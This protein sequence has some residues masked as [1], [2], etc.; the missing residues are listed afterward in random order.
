MLV[1]TNDSFFF[2]T[3]SDGRRSSFNITRCREKLKQHY[4]TSVCKIPVYPGSNEFLNMEDIYTDLSILCDLP[5]PVKPITKLLKDYTEMFTKTNK[6]MSPKRLLVLG[7]GG[8]GKSTLVG[9]IAYDWANIINGGI[10]QESGIAEI[11]PLKSISIL[12]VLNLRNVNEETTLEE[13]IR[14]QRLLPEDVGFTVEDMYEYINHNEDNTLFIFDSYDEMEVESGYLKSSQSNISKILSSKLLTGCRVLVTSR[15][16]KAHEFTQD[17]D[18][19][20]LYTKF[21]LEGF[22]KEQVE[23]YVRTFFHGNNKELGETLL[24]YFEDNNLCP[25]VAS[26]PLMTQLMCIYWRDKGGK[27]IPSKMTAFY[28]EI[29]QLM[30]KQQHKTVIARDFVNHLGQVA[31]SGLWYPHNKLV[32]PMEMVSTYVPKIEIEGAFKIGLLKRET[33]LNTDEEITNDT[34]DYASFF[35]RTFQECCA[36]HC[37]ASLGQ[38]DKHLLETKLNDLQ[39][40]KVCLQLKTILVHACGASS[41]VGKMIIRRLLATFGSTYTKHIHAYYAD[42]LEGTRAQEVQ[43]F[44]EICLLCNYESGSTVS[45]ME[46]LSTLFPKGN[47][48]F[49]GMNPYTSAAVGY[50][51]EHLNNEITQSETRSIVIMELPRQGDK[52]YLLSKSRI[53]QDAH[54]NIH[55]AL[56]MEDLSHLWLKHG[57]SSQK[58][59]PWDTD[60]LYN[61][62]ADREL[63]QQF[64]EMQPQSV[65]DYRPIF[66]EIGHVNLT[67]L[68]LSDVKLSES[69]ANTLVRILEGGCLT[70]MARFV[71]RQAGLSPEQIRRITNAIDERKIPRLRKLDVSH[72]ASCIPSNLGH[73]AVHQPLSHLN[74]SYMT[75]NPEETAAFLAV[76]AQAEPDLT[77]VKELRIHGNST[78]SFVVTTLLQVLPRLGD[79]ENLGISDVHVDE[80]KSEDHQ[81]MIGNFEYL[82]KLRELRIDDIGI[83]NIH[84]MLYGLS[85]ALPSLSELEFLRLR[86][87]PNYDGSSECSSPSFLGRFL[88][89]VDQTKKLR[90]LDVIGIYFEADLF[91]EAVRIGREHEFKVLRYLVNLNTHPDSND[92]LR[93]S[94]NAATLLQ[95]GV[96]VL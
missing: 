50:F 54:T 84:H 78:N 62:Y 27:E 72:N 55:A 13:A 49:V 25:G 10:E 66:N 52:T 64:R 17:P 88:A 41:T 44:I 71:V 69:C 21:K 20:K 74:V 75:Q 48:R 96:T 32:F 87:Q 40:P 80:L 83:H 53:L 73:V 57:F 65:V 29:I 70:Q 14:R 38:T 89:A 67:N 46:G 77:H 85:N 39:D 28:M 30:L 5:K 90:R 95:G 56:K 26:V 22:S 94:C 79:I 36:G 9:K 11:A 1:F 33:I 81:R 68:E 47:M 7:E 76:L 19:V 91:D 42:D 31:L 24:Q 51:L 45:D 23:Q 60:Y 93:V 59:L 12:I 37:L 15:L 43:N 6:Q 18:L 61:Y 86:P 34:T 58:T 3:I 4:L 35:H 92:R 8:S 16:W 82:T 63:W 2:S